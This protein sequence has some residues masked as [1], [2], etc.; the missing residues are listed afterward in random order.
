MRAEAGRP[1]VAGL[2]I[3]K[4]VCV[5]PTDEEAL[6]AARPHLESKYQAYVDWGQSEVLPQ[7]DTLR[8][9]WEEL[10]GGG[11]FVVGSP[12]TCATLLAEHVE[13]LGVGE[14]L[15]RVHWPGMPQREALRSLRLLAAEVLP[16]VRAGAAGSRS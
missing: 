14:V 8:R 3:I 5:A 4:E 6:T 11:R 2:P 15:C 16:A 7:G 9:A 1:L 12:E 13:R 10:T